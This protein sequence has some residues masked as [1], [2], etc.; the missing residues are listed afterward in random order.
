MAEFLRA[1]SLFRGNLVAI[2][3]VAC[4]PNCHRCGDLE[5]AHTPTVTFVRRG[6]FVR[7]RGRRAELADP[8]RVVFFRPDDPFRVSHPVSGGDDCTSFWFTPEILSEA[9]AGHG[10]LDRRT[11]ETRP[12]RT[13]SP[14]SSQAQADFRRVWKAARSGAEPLAV[15]EAALSLLDTVL[16]EAARGHFDA[17]E[18]RR[19]STQAAHSAAVTRVLE[20][21]ADQPA[22]RFSLDELARIAFTSRFHLARIFRRQIG[23]S[24]HEHQARLR[25]AGVLD[26]LA[27]GADDLTRLAL[28]A[29]F[30][31][32][33][34]LTREFVRRVGCAPS[35]Y[36]RRLST[37]LLAKTSTIL[38]A[39]RA[40]RG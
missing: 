33:S 6:V 26:Q 14:I 27:A 39:A 9:L 13:E 11:R 29:G 2:H 30:S 32:H 40:G 31:S 17:A 18:V 10:L 28:D 20:A 12:L 3:D 1:T 38:Q 16:G 21:L 15:E 4:R 24:I 19:Q 25:L 8:T 22:R 5:C 35:A 7:H 36:R 23:L 34:H 37:P